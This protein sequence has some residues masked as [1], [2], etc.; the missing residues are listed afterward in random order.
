MIVRWSALT[1]MFVVACAD[2]SATMRCSDARVFKNALSMQNALRRFDALFVEISA[3][4]QSALK[5][6]VFDQPWLCLVRT[7]AADACASLAL[8]V[9]QAARSKGQQK[10]HPLRAWSELDL[11]NHLDRCFAESASLV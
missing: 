9:S 10:V 11:Q 4:R 2:V 1:A 7:M 8:P 6:H 5:M 3:C